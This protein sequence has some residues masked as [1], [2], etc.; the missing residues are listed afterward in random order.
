MDVQRPETTLLSLTTVFALTTVIA[1]A[2]FQFYK[3]LRPPFSSKA[4]SLVNEGVPYLGPIRWWTKR[5]EF[6]RD[7]MK[8]QGYFSFLVGGNQVVCVSGDQAR[9][10]FL[11]H[12]DLSF[13]Y[14]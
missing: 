11:E 6:Y 10:A 14:G 1:F 8:R 2:S 9:K 4:P 5:W 12:K 13:G 3:I 7:H